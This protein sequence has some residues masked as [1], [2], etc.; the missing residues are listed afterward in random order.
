MRLLLDVESGDFAG[1]M[2][3]L[4]LLRPLEEFRGRADKSYNVPVLKA[5]LRI[6]GIDFGAPR[7]QRQLP[8]D[9]E[10]ELTEVV[11]EL[12]AEEA[13]AAARHCSRRNR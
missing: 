11:R 13:S 6:A 7:P 12:L 10:D 9:D 4:E 3:T 1:A 8:P 5:A 2:R